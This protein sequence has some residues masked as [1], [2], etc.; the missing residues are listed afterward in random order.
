M[1][2]S[3]KTT[4]CGRSMV[5]LAPLGA[6]LEPFSGPVTFSDRVHTELISEMQRLR[7]GVY[8]SDGA[9][10]PSQLTYSGRHV[11]S[12]DYESW[13]LL[14]VR[15]DGEVQGCIKFLR[16]P[17]TVRCHQLRVSD[18]PLAHSDDWAARFFSSI[19]S[20]LEAARN[21]NFS[22]VEIGGWALTPE[23]RGTAE[24]LHTVLSTYALAQIQG[25]ALGITTA[26]ERNGSAS[27][28][29]RLGGRPL[30]WDGA[31]LPPY[32]DPAYRCGMEVLRFDSRNPNARYAS[33]VNALRSHI[34]ALPVFCPNGTA[35]TGK[36][37]SLFSN[38]MQGFAQ[39]RAG[40]SAFSQA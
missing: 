15:S 28:L 35:A 30:E 26:T 39:S 38:L 12:S 2:F 34:A 23:L 40:V 3:N 13:H 17:N 6:C 25:G 21:F 14:T 4:S 11:S 7:G 33:T 22:Y 16:H 27:I 9:I 36:A 20:E 24:A 5:L 1:H 19:D 8:L 37:A 29:R 31:A 32:F 10:Q 18:A